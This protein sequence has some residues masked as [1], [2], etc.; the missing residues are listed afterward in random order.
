VYQAFRGPPKEDALRDFF[1]RLQSQGKP[2]NTGGAVVSPPSSSS[3]SSVA[4]SIDDSRVSSAA[5]SSSSASSLSLTGSMQVTGDSSSSS[6][7]PV[8]GG[9][10]ASTAGASSSGKNDFPHSKEQTNASSTPVPVAAADKDISVP[11]STLDVNGSA[12]RVSN[13]SAGNGIQK[14]RSDQE[15]NPDLAELIK[16]GIR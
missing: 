13:G 6:G 1:G 14:P 8:D 15:S 9:V 16:P 4:D 3:S 10:H 11:G 12:A 7:S 2:K 5:S